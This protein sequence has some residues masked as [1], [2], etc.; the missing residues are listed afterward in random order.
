[1]NH[2]NLWDTRDFD[3]FSHHPPENMIDYKSYFK[4]R[5]AVGETET[6]VFAA[7]INLTELKNC[8]GELFLIPNIPISDSKQAPAKEQEL[9]YF[10]SFIKVTLSVDAGAV[11]ERFTGTVALSYPVDISSYEA[12][13][14][15]LNN[16]EDMQVLPY[17][18]YE[19]DR[20][21]VC[22]PSKVNVLGVGRS[23]ME[24]IPIRAVVTD[25][26]PKERTGDFVGQKGG[27]FRRTIEEVPE[28]KVF[29]QITVR[30]VLRKAERDMYVFGNLLRYSYDYPGATN[31]NPFG[32]D[33][34][35]FDAF[36]H[37]PSD[38]IL[39]VKLFRFRLPLGKTLDVEYG[40]FV[41]RMW[42]E[43]NPEHFYLPIQAGI[44]KFA[45]IDKIPAIFYDD[46]ATVEDGRLSNASE[47]ME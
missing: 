3:Y 26:I 10:P 36:S 9:Y 21:L 11:F 23:E 22:T 16:E 39:M 44:V 41:P 42:F 8:G 13:T 35:S 6:L 24:V 15:T 18:A 32:T 19:Q 30:Y 28:D 2:Y 1:M 14:Y 4:F 38:V 20:T 33:G 46:M 12:K 43:G 25:F 40:A 7:L 45:G 47:T 37:H 29:L 31:E 17:E 34:Q 27:S 5:L